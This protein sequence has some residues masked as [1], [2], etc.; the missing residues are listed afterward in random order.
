M[1]WLYRWVRRRAGA[2]THGVALPVGAVTGWS[3][4]AWRG[5]TGGCGGGLEQPRMA[6]LY[7]WANS[8]GSV[9]RE[10]PTNGRTYT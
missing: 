6:W 2:A 4:H 3:S 9:R 7:R 1:A 10:R 8:D 5:S